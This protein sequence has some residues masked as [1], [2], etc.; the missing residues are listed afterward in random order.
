MYNLGFVSNGKYPNNEYIEVLKRKTIFNIKNI[1]SEQA[2]EGSGGL[3]VLLIQS[4]SAADVG[5]ICELLIEIRKRTNTLIWILSDKLPNTTRIIFLQLGADGIVTNQ[6]EPDEYLL[7]LRN[8]LKRYGLSEEVEE[9]LDDFKL[10]PNNLSVVIE[11]NQEISLTRL[12]FKTIEL[13]YE[14]K[15]EAIPYQ[16]IYQQVW[17][18][19]GDDVK[20]SNYR[21]ANLIFHLRKKL[22]KNPLEPKYIKTVRSKG[23]LLNV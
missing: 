17:D 7:I 4:G 1:S 16:A 12:E 5:N 2:I 15:S 13:L 19:D 14:K 22:E 11:G 3:D 21:V 23:Y 20:N 9:N 8:S 18:N 10:I 6:I